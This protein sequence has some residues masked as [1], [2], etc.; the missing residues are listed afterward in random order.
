MRDYC[1]CCRCSHAK[2][3]EERRNDTAENMH[4]PRTKKTDATSLPNTK[5]P[6]ASNGGRIAKPNRRQACFHADTHHQPHSQLLRQHE[7]NDSSGWLSLCTLCPLSVLCSPRIPKAGD[8]R[9]SGAP[10]KADALPTSATHSVV[11]W[12]NPFMLRCLVC[13]VCVGRRS[14][15]AGMRAPQNHLR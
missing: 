14:P 11:L 5:R 13:C 12:A 15:A 9:V 7:G 4:I 2:T 10:T 3:H 1:C 8:G 6:R